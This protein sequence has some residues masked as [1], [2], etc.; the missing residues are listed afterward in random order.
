MRQ[1]SAR[2]PAS[3]TRSQSAAAT[4]AVRRTHRASA[5]A[6]ARVRGER[7]AARRDRLTRS[8]TGPSCSS[9]S[10]PASAPAGNGDADAATGEHARRPR[11]GRRRRSRSAP[12]LRTPAGAPRRPSRYASISSS[13]LVTWQRLDPDRARDRDDGAVEAVVAHQRGALAREPRPQRRSRRAARP[14]CAGRSVRP[15]TGRAAAVALGQLR[16]AAARSR[17]VDAR[18]SSITSILHKLDAFCPN[19]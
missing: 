17:C 7:T 3:A 19:G 12:R 6:R 8:S 5:A 13:A 2:P 1:T 16:P 15:R 10:G 18:R 11:R 14:R 4:R 9:R